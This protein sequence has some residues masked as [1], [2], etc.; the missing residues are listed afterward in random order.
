MITGPH[1]GVCGLLTVIT[2]AHVG[3]C[4]LLTVITGAHV[5]VCE[6]LTVIAGALVGVCGLLTVITGAHV[7]MSGLLT[8]VTGAH[9]GVCGLLTVIAGAHVGYVQ[10]VR[11]QRATRVECRVQRLHEPHE[12]L[13]TVL[14]PLRARRRRGGGGRATAWRH[15]RRARQFAGRLAHQLVLQHSE[16]LINQSSVRA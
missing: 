8:V 2:G 9:V 3:V 10:T 11:R 4:G 1:V 5:G 15:E 12:R 16:R 6:L 14:L 13:G 7:G